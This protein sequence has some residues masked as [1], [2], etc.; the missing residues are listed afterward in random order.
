MN[1][2]VFAICNAELQVLQSTA[3]LRHPESKYG[4]HPPLALETYF[5]AL[6]VTDGKPNVV[7]AGGVQATVDGGMTVWPG[8]CNAHQYT[9]EA[10]EAKVHR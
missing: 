1:E 9:D 2:Q 4:S 10:V 6:L 5:T 3:T 8:C 7:I